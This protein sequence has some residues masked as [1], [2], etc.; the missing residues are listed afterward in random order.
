MKAAKLLAIMAAAL[1]LTACVRQDNAEQEALAAAES[2]A[3]LPETALEGQPEPPAAVLSVAQT[4]AAAAE[5]GFLL[6]AA[7]EARLILTGYAGNGGRISIPHGVSEIGNEAFLNSANISGVCIPD[8]VTAIGAGAFHGAN[9]SSVR[10]PNSVTTIGAWAFSDN[11]NLTS[12]FI[13]ESAT[14]I[15]AGAFHGANLTSVY[16]PASVTRI[17]AWAFANNPNLTSLSG[18]DS[19]SYIGAYAFWSAGLTFVSFPSLASLGEEAFPLSVSRIRLGGAMDES[20]WH[21]AALSAGLR[22]AYFAQAQEL[23]AGTYATDN[24]GANAVWRRE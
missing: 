7:D 6:Y 13:S 3:A 8:S 21:D 16:I 15:G 9:L 1:I 17:G 23:R 12:V 10:I 14:A 24:P 2:Q 5:A 22:E 20:A 11:P 4:Q 18:G 19:V